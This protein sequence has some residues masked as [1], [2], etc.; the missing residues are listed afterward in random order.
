MKKYRTTSLGLRDCCLVLADGL[1]RG[2]GGLVKHTENRNSKF[3]KGCFFEVVPKT[4]E[5][6]WF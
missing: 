2:G 4:K 3:F 1:A 5:F 6:Q